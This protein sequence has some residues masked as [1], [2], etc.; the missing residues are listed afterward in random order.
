MNICIECLK[1]K[2][3]SFVLVPPADSEYLLLCPLLPAQQQMAEA[4][5]IMP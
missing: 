2:G 3:S 1:G 5:P 4:A